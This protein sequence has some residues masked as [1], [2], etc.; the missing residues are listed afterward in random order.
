M[1]AASFAS[2]TADTLSSE[3][4]NVYGK[5]FYN[6]I[7]LKKDRRGLNGVIS[8]EG[9]LIGIIGSSVIAVIYL[10]AFGYDRN[11]FIIVIAGTVGNVFE[12][13][14]WCNS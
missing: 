7:T 4:G 11:F 8:F 1:L 3:L 9:T 13:G 6:I 14:S 2:A 5:R 10:I 12:L